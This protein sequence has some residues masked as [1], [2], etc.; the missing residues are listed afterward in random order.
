MAAGFPADPGQ[1][2]VV[3]YLFPTP[4]LLAG[5]PLRTPTAAHARAGRFCYDTMTLVGPGT[6]PAAR[7]AG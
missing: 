4:G 3:G 2:R 7:A 5:L 6:Y 1:D